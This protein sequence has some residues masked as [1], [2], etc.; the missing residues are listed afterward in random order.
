MKVSPLVAP[1]GPVERAAGDAA[2]FRLENVDQQP[3]ADDQSRV[4]RRTVRSVE[5]VDRDRAEH[6]VW[7]SAAQR[8]ADEVPDGVHSRCSPSASIVP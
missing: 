3:V 7:A 5:V 4:G 1:G 2:R 8:V 6:L